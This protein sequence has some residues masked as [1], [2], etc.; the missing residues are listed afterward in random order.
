MESNRLLSLVHELIQ[1]G[2]F[3][4]SIA[5]GEPM[6][7]PDIFPLLELF[8]KTNS[9]LALLTNGTTLTERNVS[10]LSKIFSNNPKFLLQVS[11]DS[12]QQAENDFL[13]GEHEKVVSGIER[14]VKTGLNMQISTVLT[15]R[16]INNAHLVINRFYPGVKRFHFVSIQRTE[17]SMQEPE[18]LITDKMA[19]EFWENLRNY[20]RKFP[21]DLKLPSLGVM[22]RSVGWEEYAESTLHKSAT[23]D[24]AVCSAGITHVEITHDFDVLGCD[25]AK[26]YSSIGNVKSI[27]FETVWHSEA[28]RKLRE[29][30]TPACYNVLT[31]VSSTQLNETSKEM[32][33]ALQRNG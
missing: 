25:I 24:C 15:S 27:A 6:L 32:L 7:H 17:K 29:L 10:N 30:K 21:D 19:K 31:N 14:A 1:L 23:F 2:V 5:G 9:Q 18:L 22:E 33:V 28:A 11:L 26:D 12:V 16:N 3:E 13:R 8:S 20:K 4:F